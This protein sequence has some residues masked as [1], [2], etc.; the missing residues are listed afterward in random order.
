MDPP[1]P[2]AD[3]Q[4]VRT[5]KSEMVTRAW[6][7]TARPILQKPTS[8]QVRIFDPALRPNPEAFRVGD[9]V[10]ADPAVAE[11]WRATRSQVMDHLLRVLVNSPWK[12]HLV[13][14]GSL[15]L[16][17]WL[18][19]AAR[20]PGDIDW[21]ISPDSIEMVSPLGREMIDGL[22]RLISEHAVAGEAVINVAEVSVADIW[23]YERAPGQR[24]LVPWSAPG[25]PRGVVQ[26]DLVFG[27]N[28]PVPPVLTPMSTSDGD[29]I[30]IYAATPELALAWKLLWLETDTYPQGKD[31]YDAVLL[32]EQTR[33]PLHLLEQVLREGEYPPI[34][35]L[36]ADFPLEWDVDWDNFK[37]EYPWVDGGARDWQVR[38]TAALAP[39]FVAR[40]EPLH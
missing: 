14:R 38:L 11:R 26:M 1:N 32:A 36:E 5:P 4:L 25:L 3:N 15:L 24:F 13:L 40:A 9:P 22:L 31:L 23:T 20:Q 2:A 35:Q 18:G 37:Q 10:F 21:V 8:D 7:S 33:L 34:R 19:E 29:S 17:A 6:P 27:E 28:L 12:D 30:S 39:M 16:K